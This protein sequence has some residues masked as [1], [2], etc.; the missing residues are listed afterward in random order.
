VPRPRVL[1]AG[2]VSDRH[3]NRELLDCCRD[4]TEQ[5]R[6]LDT[7]LGADAQVLS[8]AV[9][10]LL[11]ELALTLAA[12]PEGTAIVTGRTLW[13][14]AAPR[15]QDRFMSVGQRAL[16]T[17]PEISLRIADAVLAARPNSRA[18]WR[19]R[20]LALEELGELAAAIEAH[21]A[22]LSRITSDTIGAGQNV[23][24]LR[25]RLAATRELADALGA[26]LAVARSTSGLPPSGTVDL[27]G[28]PDPADPAADLDDLGPEELWDA[29]FRL[30]HSGDW[31][32][33]KARY[34]AAARLLVTEGAAPR[35]V[36]SAVDQLA[37]KTAHHEHDRLADSLPLLTS[38]ATY[39]RA[40]DTALMD[41][42]AATGLDVIGIGDFRNLVAGR[43]ICLVANSERVAKGRWGRRIDEYDLVVRF[44][45]YAIDPAATGRRTDI[46][47][48]VHLHDFNWDKKVAIRLVF[49][50]SQNA[51]LRSL[52]QRLVPGA[53]DHVGD[54]SLRWPVRDVRYVDDQEIPGIPTSGFNMVRLLDHLDVNPV[55]DLVGF[56]FYETGPYR[57]TEAMRL[58]V[59]PQHSYQYEKAWVLSHATS[60]DEMRI[61]LR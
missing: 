8:S 47:A 56:D 61:S 36:V 16:T 60:S 32:A 58:P 15:L 31:P 30:E 52:K 4:L 24:Q 49:S 55:I 21:E 57:L 40:G 26:E 2:G 7:S 10:G 54:G 33:A 19:L 6:K 3:A 18:A 43:S 34:V 11:Q 23:V 42:D 41:A 22:Y 5:S 51:W 29:G 28:P 38:L 20:A 44:N 27:T 59:S 50:G 12:E 13:T 45:S 25:R 14:D 48:T 53:Q 1:E 37:A 9:S 35:V 17:Q 39:G 46:H